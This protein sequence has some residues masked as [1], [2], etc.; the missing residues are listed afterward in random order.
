MVAR[1]AI[2]P[3]IDRVVD[4]AIDIIMGDCMGEAGQSFWGDGCLG[5]RGQGLSIPFF[6]TMSCFVCTPRLSFSLIR[7]RFLHMCTL[8]LLSVYNL[9]FLLLAYRLDF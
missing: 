3:G 8:I 4:T 6:E 2:Q 7:L 5:K 9:A 1:Y